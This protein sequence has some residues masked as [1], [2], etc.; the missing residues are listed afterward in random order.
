MLSW[1]SVVSAVVSVCLLEYRGSPVT[2][3]FPLYSMKALALT[4]KR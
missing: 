2:Y 3:C 1:L 4:K